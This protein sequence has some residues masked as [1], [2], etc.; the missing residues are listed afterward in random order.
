MKQPFWKKA[1]SYLF[2]YP[3]E[4]TGS[5]YNPELYVQL[6]KGRYQLSTHN[7]IYSFADKYDNFF[8]TFTA[9]DLPSDE[10][11]IDVLILGLGMA[12]IPYMLENNFNKTYSYTAVEIDEEVTYLASKYVLD[13]LKSEIQLITADAY[14]FLLMDDS[15][16]DII[17]MDVFDSDIVP[18]EF[19]SIDFLQLL[20]GALSSDGLLIYNRLFQS[21]EDEKVSNAFYNGNFLDTFPSGYALDIHGNKMLMNTSKYLKKKNNE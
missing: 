21:K 11:S 3:I 13:E 8:D 17:A 6:V 2:D 5:D 12:S 19:E 20:K 10:S 18:E 16:Y 4:S 7:A 15:K 1:L 14:S 9:L